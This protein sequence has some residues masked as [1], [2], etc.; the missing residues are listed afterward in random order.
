MTCQIVK[1]NTCIL[2]PK[3]YLLLREQLNPNYK[4]ICD[5]LLHTG[6]RVEEFWEFIKHPEWYKPSRRCIDLP[7]TAIRKRSLIKERSVILTSNGCEVIENVLKLNLKKVSR[8]AMNEAISRAAIKADIGDE[9]I[10]PKMFRKT[11]ISWLVKCYPDKQLWIAA[12]SGH[13][14][15]TLLKHYL[16]IGFAAE[17]VD[18]MRKFL[19]GWNE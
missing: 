9:Y 19:K 6:M 17:D 5:A 14:L 2:T 15:E 16:G 7:K 13:T 10:C 4:T 3:V 8:V 12:S 11:L 1:Q 18:D